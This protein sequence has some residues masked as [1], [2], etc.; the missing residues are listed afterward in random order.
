M[1]AYRGDRVCKNNLLIACGVLEKQL[2]AGLQERVLHPDVIDYTFARFEKELARSM[3]RQ[4]SETAAAHRQLR[5]IETEIR[6]CTRAIASDGLM[7]FL[8]TRLASEATELE[9]QHRDLTE[10][11]A[12]SDPRAMRPQ[13]RDSRRFLKTRLQNLR[14][15]FGGEPRLVRA[16]I[17]QH[18]QKITLTPTGES[19]IASGAWDWLGG[20]AVRMVPGARIELATPAFSGRRSTSELPRHG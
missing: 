14:S 19:Y 13:L 18:V 5:K 8:R 9:T 11:I 6:N 4:S 7:S 10:K 2:L 20:V 17:A 15:L 16:A 3:N 1:H 12:A